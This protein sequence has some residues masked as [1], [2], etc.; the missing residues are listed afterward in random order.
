MKKIL[1]EN[2]LIWILSIISIILIG[3]S[4][5]TLRQHTTCSYTIKNEDYEEQIDVIIGYTSF[6]ITKKYQFSQPEIL[7]SELEGNRQ[8]GYDV[9][10]DNNQLIATKKMK[11][12]KNYYKTIEQ[13]QK[14]GYQCHTNFS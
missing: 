7:S 4:I 14:E 11:L 3:L 5:I 13:Y 12:N 2:K 9:M 1:M 8:D 10:I 6:T